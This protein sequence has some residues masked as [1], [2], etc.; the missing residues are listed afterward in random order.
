MHWNCIYAGYVV[1]TQVDQEAA[2]MPRCTV[3][4]SNHG[5]AWMELAIY[6][7]LAASLSSIGHIASLN[8]M[9]P[10]FPRKTLPYPEVK[11]KLSF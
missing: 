2:G 11:I 9:H 3:Q 1:M 4:K 5:N 10:F 6:W 7:I 8:D